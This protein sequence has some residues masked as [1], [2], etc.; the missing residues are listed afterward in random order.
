M[1]TNVAVLRLRVPVRGARY[2]SAVGET[3]TVMWR[4]TVPRVVA[5]ARAGEAIDWG[6]AM[7]RFGEYELQEKEPTT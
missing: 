6:G 4:Q 2:D 1:K 7:V 5:Q 3:R